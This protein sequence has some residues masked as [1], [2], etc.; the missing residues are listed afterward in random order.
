MPALPVF[1]DSKSLPPEVIRYLF[2]CY[3]QRC[4]NA[5]FLIISE[6]LGPQQRTCIVVFRQARWVFEMAGLT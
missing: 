1:Q 5:L 6:L 2:A 3:S 4:Y